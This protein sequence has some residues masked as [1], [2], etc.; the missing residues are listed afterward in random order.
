IFIDCPGGEEK[1]GI[2]TDAHEDDQSQVPVREDRDQGA[3]TSGTDQ[4]GGNHPQ[5]QASATVAPQGAEQENEANGLGRQN[6]PAQ[7]EVGERGDQQQV[8]RDVNKSI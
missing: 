5:Q 6:R 2:S 8:S 1:D 4:G 7:A 3:H